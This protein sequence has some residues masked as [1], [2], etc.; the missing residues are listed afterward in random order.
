NGEVLD[1]NSGERAGI[2][3]GY[4]DLEEMRGGFNGKD[5]I[6]L[7]GGGW[8]GK[9]GLGVNIG[10]KV[11]RDEDDFCVGMFCLEMGADEL[12]TAM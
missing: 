10:E 4:G 3:R 2:R 9:S 7:G 1:E 12:A 5:L 8:V 6:M 11:G